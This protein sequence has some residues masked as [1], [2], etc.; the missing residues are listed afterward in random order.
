[1]MNGLRESNI[2]TEV[3]NYCQ[4][5]YENSCFEAKNEQGLHRKRINRFRVM[6]VQP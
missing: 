4:A 6:R 2:W 3:R 5:I 1:V